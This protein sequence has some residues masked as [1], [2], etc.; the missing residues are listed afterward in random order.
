MQQSNKVFQLCSFCK[1]PVGVSVKHCA[2]CKKQEG[3]REKILKQLE[4]D[5]EN[6]AKGFNISDKIFGFDRKNC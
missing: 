4:I 1:E 5:K 3:R 6:K 2:V